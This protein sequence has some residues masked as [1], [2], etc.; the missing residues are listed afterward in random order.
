MMIKLSMNKISMSFFIFLS[1][2]SFSVFS[3]TKTL[4]FS[5]DTLSLS[6]DYIEVQ[7]F[8]KGERIR[9]LEINRSKD[10]VVFDGNEMDFVE[11]YNN[12]NIYELGTSGTSQYRDYD[13]HRITGRLDEKLV[14]TEPDGEIIFTYDYEYQCYK[15]EPLF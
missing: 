6:K 8:Q 3:E 13:F 10:K 14:Y 11:D 5:C 7:T 9:G 2:L 15:T 4:Y 1:I 12:D